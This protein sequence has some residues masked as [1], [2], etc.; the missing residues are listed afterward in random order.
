MYFRDAAIVLLCYDVTSR[1]SFASID[2]WK[3]FVGRQV[4][5]CQIFLVGTKRD[6]AGAESIALAELR[7]KAEDGEHPCVETSALTG[8]GVGALREMLANAV[9]RAVARAPDLRPRPIR[10]DARLQGG[11]C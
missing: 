3:A 9:L 7:A 11:C 8:E 1:G 6:L 10:L 2:D 4:P 5:E